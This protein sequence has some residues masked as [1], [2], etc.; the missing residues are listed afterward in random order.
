VH[1]NVE[2]SVARNLN[3][4]PIDVTKVGS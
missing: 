3:I 4:R 1:L 2:E